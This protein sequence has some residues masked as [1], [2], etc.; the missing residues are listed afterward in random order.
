M[1]ILPFIAQESRSTESD[2]D[3]GKGTITS[4]DSTNSLDSSGTVGTNMNGSMP[5]LTENPEQFE[6]RKQQKEIWENGID[7]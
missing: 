5:I 1:I 2:T 6:V 4:Y 3:S 7:M